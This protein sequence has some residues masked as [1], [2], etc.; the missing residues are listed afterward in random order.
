MPAIPRVALALGALVIAA[1]VIFSLPFLLNLGGAPR[2]DHAGDLGRSVRQRP[3]STGPSTST[4]PVAATAPD[5]HGG[6]RDT[7]V[8]IAKKFGLTVAVL[9]AANPQIKNPNNIKIGDKINI[10]SAAP[11]NV[12]SG[13]SP[14]PS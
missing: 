7:M 4:G 2:S 10:P 8:K 1:G 6:G 12:I 5:L 13:A 9:E 3:P 14:S 11:S